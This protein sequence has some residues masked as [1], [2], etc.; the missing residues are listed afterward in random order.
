[1]MYSKL[2]FALAISTGVFDI[3]IAQDNGTD[4]GGGDELALDE[5]NVQDAS[6]EDG[7][8]NAEEGELASDT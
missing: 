8:A 5:D 4:F 2:L 7:L 3:V 1:M 6:Q